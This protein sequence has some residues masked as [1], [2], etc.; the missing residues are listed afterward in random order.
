M[1]TAYIR[2]HFSLLLELL[3][4]LYVTFQYWTKSTNTEF[5]SRVFDKEPEFFFVAVLED[6]LAISFSIFSFSAARF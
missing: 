4:G 1:N 2:F 5:G 6:A 3:E